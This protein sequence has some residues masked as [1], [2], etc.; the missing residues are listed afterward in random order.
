MQA[1]GLK[2]VRIKSRAG[3]GRKTNP[4]V[5][6]LYPEIFSDFCRFKRLGV[7]LAPQVARNGCSNSVGGVRA[8]PAWESRI[9]NQKERR[10]AVVDK[11][12]SEMGTVI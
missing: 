3:R 5:E 12:S 4:W 1:A 7:K 6:A 2:R 11:N 8:R 10:G 9:T